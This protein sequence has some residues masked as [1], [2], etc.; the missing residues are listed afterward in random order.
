MNLDETPQQVRELKIKKFQP[1]AKKDLASIFSEPIA[2]D[3]NK[4]WTNVKVNLPEMNEGF[5]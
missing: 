3:L 2:L 5:E 1:K 4:I